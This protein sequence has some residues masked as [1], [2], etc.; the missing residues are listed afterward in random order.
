MDIDGIGKV[1]QSGIARKIVYTP[2]VIAVDF[3][4]KNFAKSVK[5][6]M[7]KSLI[8][9]EYENGGTLEGIDRSKIRPEVVFYGSVM[10]ADETEELTNDM[11]LLKNK[12]VDRKGLVMK[13]NDEVNT[14]E[15]AIKL[16]EE[17][18]KEQPEQQASSPFQLRRPRGTGNAP[19]ENQNA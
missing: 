9:K 6:L 5:E 8:V 19:N 3:L 10:P 17:I 7:T 11:T 2:T 4:R 1:A 12:L 16:I 13:Y 18:D 15:D 14:D